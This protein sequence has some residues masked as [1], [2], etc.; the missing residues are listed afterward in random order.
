[1]T[2]LLQRLAGQA[3]GASGPRIRSAAAA[4]AQVPIALP[5]RGQR[6]SSNDAQAFDGAE[7]PITVAPVAVTAPGADSARQAADTAA[8]SHTREAER[9]PP[10]DEGMTRPI[11][12]IAEP[13]PVMPDAAPV[14]PAPL[15]GHLATPTL[16]TAGTI[17][18]V[19]PDQAKLNS[20][21]EPTEVHVH[22]GRI[23][24]TALPSPA[25]PKQRER[26]SRQNVP[27]SDYLAKR[28]SS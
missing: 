2:G 26:P 7:L 5:S 1:M 10:S 12:G 17:R 22:I 25:A 8:R 20:E 18:P 13:A 4:H 14:A 27:L 16:P 11:D 28:R 21:R 15:L 6:D 3:L 9:R 19:V 24:V 23:E